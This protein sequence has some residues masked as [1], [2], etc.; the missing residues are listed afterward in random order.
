VKL[1]RLVASAPFVTVAAFTSPAGPGGQPP[2]QRPLRDRPLRVV[3]NH[4]RLVVVRFRR[5]RPDRTDPL[6]RNGGARPV[7]P[8]TGGSLYE[9]AAAANLPRRI[10]RR[11]LPFRAGA[12]A[13]RPRV[14]GTRSGG[15][16]S[17]D[18]S[19]SDET[20]QTRSRLLVSPPGA[21]SAIVLSSRAGRRRKPTPSLDDVSFKPDFAGECSRSRRSLG[22]RSPRPAMQTD[23]WSGTPPRPAP[24]LGPDA[25]PAPCAQA[26][27]D[28]PEPRPSGDSLSSDVVPTS[29][30]VGKGGPCDRV[31]VR[32]ADGGLEASRACDRERGE[33]GKRNRDSRPA[34][35]RPAGP[36][37]TSSASP[38]SR[39]RRFPRCE[40]RRVQPERRDTAVTIFF[41]TG[42]AAPSDPSQRTWR[43]EWF[44]V[45]DILRKTGP[46]LPETRPRSSSTRG[47]RSSPF[48]IAVDNRS[49]DPTCSPGT[50]PSASLI[51]ARR[52]RA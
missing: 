43:A 42:P 41:A 31:G 35:R 23:L 37:R 36:W 45:N 22:P 48:V 24:V 21:E 15:G 9:L 7:R 27:M 30:A 47:S 6:V 1:A 49:G 2:R 11:W 39:Q 20:R 5:S 4:E 50:R 12:L 14:Q 3:S 8:V 51:P 46:S 16:L 13:G 44:Q 28:L 34:P 38:A 25:L 10:E 29:S 33:P 18:F 40:R 19:A 52:L 26:G 32:P 17:L